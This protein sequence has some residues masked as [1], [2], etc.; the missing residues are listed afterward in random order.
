LKKSAKKSVAI[1]RDEFT[2]LDFLY[3]YPELSPRIKQL[4]REFK[5]NSW[6]R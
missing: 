4:E 1:Q 2:I 5:N 3:R 6:S